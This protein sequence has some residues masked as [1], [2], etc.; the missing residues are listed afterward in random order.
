V[1]AAAVEEL[2]ADR[3]PEQYETLADHYAEGEEWPKALHYLEK[4]GDKATAAYA[5]QD[6]LEF[7]AR[8]LDVGSK[9]GET[10]L[11]TVAGVAQKRGLVNFGTGNLPAASADF[12]RMLSAARGVRDQHLEGSA[13]TCRA[14]VESYFHQFETAE[15]TLRAA[16]TIAHEGFDDVRFSA[17][18]WLGFTLTTIN[19]H[20][21]AEVALRDTEALASLVDDPIGRSF[22]NVV[23]GQCMAWTG[24]FDEAL[25]ILGRWR[26]G[27]ET[28]RYSIGFAATQWAE[29]LARGGKGEVEPALALLKE[30]VTMG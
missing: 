16:L 12:E 29:G 1:V 28:S 11:A 5:N 24:R 23:N 25:A 9:L 3:L 2:Y 18:P 22:L 17:S 8:T 19:R 10:A 6:A 13:L 7:Y 26:Q 4:A 27:I 21:E 15:A 14:M 20:A 30:V